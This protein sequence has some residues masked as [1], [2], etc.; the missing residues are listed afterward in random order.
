MFYIFFCSTKLKYSF[1]AE[2]SLNYPESVKWRRKKKQKHNEK[3]FDV[4]N[5]YT[6]VIRIAGISGKVC[7]VILLQKHLNWY[8][9]H[10]NLG[11]MAMDLSEKRTK[12]GKYEGKKALFFGEKKKVCV[13]SAE[14]I[15]MIHH[16][17]ISKP[18]TL[19]RIMIKQTLFAKQPMDDS[20]VSRRGTSNW[21]VNI[22]ENSIIQWNGYWANGS[23]LARPKELI[24]RAYVRLF[25]VYCVSVPS[26]WR[27]LFLSLPTLSM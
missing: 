27:T 19:L 13:L 2:L 21:T 11:S 18:S 4:Q 5:E 6:L 23:E 14:S 12:N 24:V 9:M 15:S 8:Q 20:M 17:L 1:F 7:D 16:F 26:G 25:C 10:W 3:L 22:T